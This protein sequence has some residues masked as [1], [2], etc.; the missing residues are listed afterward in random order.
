MSA[1]EI[2][3]RNAAGVGRGKEHDYVWADHAAREYWLG[4]ADAILSALR[5]GGWA[6]VPA[7]T[8]QEG[9][10]ITENLI[11]HLAYH[12]SYGVHGSDFYVCHACHEGGA[13]GA[14]SGHKDNCPVFAVE[15]WVSAMIAA[16]EEEQS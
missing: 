6:V 5:E 9:A 12:D 2:I 7:E 16:A 3:A 4:R 14:W 10:T 8:L 13:P 11:S 1:R 15:T